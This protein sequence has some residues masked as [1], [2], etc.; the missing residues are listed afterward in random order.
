MSHPHKELI[1]PDFI[2]RDIP[3]T[4]HTKWKLYATAQGISMKDFCYIA[5][6]HEVESIE[7]EFNNDRGHKEP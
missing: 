1:M 7:E 2:L 3:K 6:I 4:L 5:L